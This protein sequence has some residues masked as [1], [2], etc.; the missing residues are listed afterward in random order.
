MMIMMKPHSML[1]LLPPLGDGRAAAA[2][3]GSIIT[4]VD[5]ELCQKLICRCR[6]A[7]K[8]GASY[9][10]VPRYSCGTAS[11]PATAAVAAHNPMGLSQGATAANLQ[12]VGSGWL[13]LVAFGM[14]PGFGPC[15]NT[16]LRTFDF[17]SAAREP[18]AA[19]AAAAGSRF[20]APFLRMTCSFLDASILNIFESRRGL[21]QEEEPC[22]SISISFN[23][24]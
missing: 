3:R 6:Q 23:H 8:S 16:S 17:P 15:H 14:P 20:V 12:Q 18:C 10:P 9:V 24:L 2:S 1:L 13:G 19:A 21:V 4:R 5:D 22:F 11:M 7:R